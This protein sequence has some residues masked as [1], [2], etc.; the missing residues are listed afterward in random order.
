MGQKLGWDSPPLTV[1]R[2]VH[3]CPASSSHALVHQ[4]AQRQEQIRLQFRSG[5]LNVLFATSV[6]SEGL[7]FRQCQ[8]VLAFDRPDNVVS[9]VQ[10]GGRARARDSDFVLL[11]DTAAAGAKAV[12]KLQR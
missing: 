8:L 2:H 10:S 5:H 4:H 11:Y 3:V 12:A 9:L 6:G 1:R 7:D